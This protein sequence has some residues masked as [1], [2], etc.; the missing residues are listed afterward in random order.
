M[1][2][3]VIGAPFS[4][5]VRGGELHGRRYGPDD[6]GAPRV[7]AVHGVT[8]SSLAWQAVAAE[9]DGV[10][11]LAPDLRGRGRSRDLPPPYGI[12]QHAEDLAALMDAS[13]M[14]RPVVVGHS[15]GAFCAVALADIAEVSALVLVDG[16]FPL[17]A[18]PGADLRE[19]VPAILGPAAERLE[20]EFPDVAAYLAYWRQ[21]PALAPA[22]SSQIEEYLAYDLHGTPP[23]LRPS[24]VIEAVLVDTE[25]EFSAPW[26]RDAMRRL[27]VP[28]V[29]LRAPRGLL[30]AEPLYPP[31]R[32]E[33]FR[34]DI[35]QLTVVEVDDVNHYT[36]AMAERGARAVAEVVRRLL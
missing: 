28:V 23:A 21:H 5:G 34:A 3:P 24:T 4:A 22:W 13:G 19:L 15:M 20:M 29:A 35:P 17:I 12:R 36:I 33:E 32:I 7:L 30:D 16:G 9:L 14:R 6:D 11:I 31:G 18:P 25:D 1:E 2:R 8:A 27:G 26:Y 10:R